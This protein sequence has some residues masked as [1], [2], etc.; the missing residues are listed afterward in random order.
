MKRQLNFA[1]AI[2]IVCG[3]LT[4]IAQAQTSG[5]QRMRANIPFAFN[6]GQKTLPAGVYTV[7]VVNPSSDRKVLQIRSADGH[8]T[9]MVQTTGVGGRVAEEA[10]LMFRRYG[11]RYFFAQAHMA[12]DSISLATAISGAERATRRTLVRGHEKSLV[13]V[14]GE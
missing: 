11:D 4:I 9:A 14:I 13:A 8:A 1:I 7:T 6:V 5:P 12:G 10:K 3:V 2:I